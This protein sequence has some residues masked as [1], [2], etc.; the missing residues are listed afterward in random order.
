VRLEPVI[1]EAVMLE[2][3]MLEPVMLEPMMFEVGV[4]ETS[5]FAFSLLGLFGL[6]LTTA[7][8]TTLEV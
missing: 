3:A 6:E 8:P 7:C 2:A 5:R 4:L 1:F